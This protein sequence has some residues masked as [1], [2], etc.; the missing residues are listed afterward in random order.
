M[1][2]NSQFGSL[3]TPTLNAVMF[4]V[5]V[6]MSFKGVDIFV[7]LVAIVFGTVG[8]PNHSEQEHVH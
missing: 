5:F 3:L 7:T 2:P 6:L 4:A 8:L 1:G